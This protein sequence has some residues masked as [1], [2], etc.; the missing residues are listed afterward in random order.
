MYCN[1]FC[2][3]LIL[4]STWWLFFSFFLGNVIIILVSITKFNLN[5]KIQY[6]Q[7]KTIKYNKRSFKEYTVEEMLRL[8]WGKWER[9]GCGVAV[10]WHGR[11]RVWGSALFYF[12]TLFCRTKLMIL[13][14]G[15][16]TTLADIRLRVP[17]HLSLPHVSRW[18]EALL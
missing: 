9:R 12:I 1:L 16:W 15:F 14:G 10:C 7:K 8:G 4:Q 5:N 3:E 6:F 11:R 17:T 18:T 13:G 2:R